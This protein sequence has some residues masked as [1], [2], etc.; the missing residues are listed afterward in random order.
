[1]KSIRNQMRLDK[2]TQILPKSSH[3]LCLAS[4]ALVGT[5]FGVPNGA[6]A[7]S[8]KDLKTPASPLVLQARGS[9]YVGG[10]KV[11]QTSVE[12]SPAPDVPFRDDQ[13][14]VNQMYVE[15][16][17]PHGASKVPLVLIHGATLSGKTY[18]TTPDGRMGWFEYFV[19][20]GHPV[21]VPD[22]VGRA[23]SGFNQAV[24]NDVAAGLVSPTQQPRFFRLGDNWGSW[25]NFRFGPQPGAAYHDTKFPVSKA[26]ELSKQDIPDVNSGLP[27]PNP[28]IKALADL[29][30]SV[31]GAVLIGHSQS[32]SFPLRAALADPRG[33][34]G[35]V[36][37]ETG[38]C[39]GAV[40]V[41]MWTDQEIAK[42]ARIPLLVVF[43]DH[44][45]QDTGTPYVHLWHE[46]FNQCKA[47]I[48]RINAAGGNAQ[49]LWPPDLG[50]QGNSHMIM[51]DTNNRQIGDMILKWVA[52]NVH[53]K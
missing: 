38:S 49:M 40:G 6:V 33:V 7:Q 46:S 22:Q 48:G 45:R 8:I 5:L 37:V 23:R 4:V 42:L 18:D 31:D 36:M 25:T 35:M 39:M 27:T 24:F 12:V 34:K 11:A 41:P 2:V 43:G 20:K 21:Y 1:M 53:S 14:T 9:F 19:R 3:P 26:D 28:T 15:Y 50:I 16:M 13:V 17:I 52:E 44:L 51:Q 30:N 47:L 10:E 32:G 29:A